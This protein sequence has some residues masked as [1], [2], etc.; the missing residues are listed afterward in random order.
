MSIF[1]FV[2]ERVEIPLDDQDTNED[3]VE[4]ESENQNNPGEDGP[5]VSRSSFI[6]LLSTVAIVLV[7]LHI[8][9]TG[10]M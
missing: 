7:S 10:Y 1:T 9:V 4:D 2:D 5:S 8:V 6:P 3:K